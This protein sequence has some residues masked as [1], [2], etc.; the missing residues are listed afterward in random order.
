MTLKGPVSGATRGARLSENTTPFAPFF[1]YLGSCT[2]RIGHFE[3]WIVPLISPIVLERPTPVDS[4]PQIGPRQEICTTP[5][6]TEC[7]WMD[8][9]LP[10]ANLSRTLLPR[11]AGESP[12]IRMSL[13]G[14][15]PT[16]VLHLWP[17]KRYHFLYIILRQL[18]HDLSGNYDSSFVEVVVASSSVQV[19]GTFEIRRLVVHLPF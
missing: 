3:I 18:P 11:S 17:H 7:L 6:S 4:T 2:L 1:Y 12:K 15:S 19:R 9:Y 10:H 8:P 5:T 13:S 14:T 16:T